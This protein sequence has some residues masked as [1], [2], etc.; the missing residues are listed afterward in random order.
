V[1]AAI[2]G[3]P[4]LLYLGLAGLADRSP[5]DFLG[6]PSG[7]ETSFSGGL[8]YMW[9]LL[10]PPLPFMTDQFQGTYDFP[11][12][13]VYFTGLVG[14]FGWFQYGFAPWVNALAAGIGTVIVGLAIAALV[15]RRDAVRRRWAEL[16]CYG[17]FVVGLFV[18]IAVGGYYFRTDTGG[19]F[20]QARYL[21][22]LLPLYVGVVALAPRG[23]GRRLEPIVTGLIVALVAGHTVFALLLTITRF[24]T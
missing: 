16:A 21:L 24:Y 23:A 5:R 4:T 2:I 22:P 19:S 9:Q 3:V 8:S 13:D 15:R 6:L 10:L 1:A 11:P 7:G 12:W 18:V 14:R 20:E 17:S